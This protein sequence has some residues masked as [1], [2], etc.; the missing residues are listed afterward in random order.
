MR[1]YKMG[2]LKDKCTRIKKHLM[3]ELK[4]IYPG[5]RVMLIGAS[6]RPHVR[7]TSF[8]GKLHPHSM[9]NH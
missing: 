5:D 7:I 8:H 9:K 3:K 4:Q 2:G 6:S 1:A